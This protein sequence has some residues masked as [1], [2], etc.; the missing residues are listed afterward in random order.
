MTEERDELQGSEEEGPS[1]GGRKRFLV[2]G[3]LG[4]AVGAVTAMLL[5]PWRGAEARK[6]LK[7]GA[8]KAG[9]AVKDK[10]VTVI[11]RGKGEEEEE[12]D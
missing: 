2:V 9:S 12:E 1:R 10:A 7:E 3:L 8:Q 11:R 5:T 4:A 6:K